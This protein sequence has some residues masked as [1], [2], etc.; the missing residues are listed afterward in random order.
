MSVHGFKNIAWPELQE[1]REERFKARTQMKGTAI[2]K[3]GDYN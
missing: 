3:G 1:V 2:V